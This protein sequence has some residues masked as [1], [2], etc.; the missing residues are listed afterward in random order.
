MKQLQ[1]QSNG[2]LVKF[3]IGLKR[4]LFNG[5]LVDN[6]FVGLNLICQVDSQ[7]KRWSVFI[8]RFVESSGD[9]ISR[10]KMRPTAKNLM[11][12]DSLFDRSVLI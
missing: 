4:F 1:L 10:Y 12:D 5:P 3:I 11:R 9:L 2:W 7:H 8:Y 6:R